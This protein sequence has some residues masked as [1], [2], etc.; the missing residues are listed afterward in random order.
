MLSFKILNRLV[1]FL[2]IFFCANLH[3]QVA[4]EWA[5][6]YGGAGS[7]G[8]WQTTVTSD[9]SGN[10]YLAGTTTSTSAISFN[11]HQNSFGGGTYDAFLVKFD[12]NGNRLW[13]TYYG[14]TGNEYGEA[15]ITDASGNI[16]LTGRTTSSSGI[17]SSG[18]LN[19]YAGSTDAFLVKFNS[20]GV[21]QWGTY[22]GG[23]NGDD[24][25]TICVDGSG[26]IYMSGSSAS[27]TGI[28][29]G[30]F[31]N[32]IGGG[33]GDAFLVKFD[34]NC[35][36]LWATYYGGTGSEAGLAITTDGLGNVY[37]TGQTTSTTAIA[38]GGFQNTHGGGT[39]DSYLV[40][41]TASG[42]RSWATYYGGTGQERSAG[43]TTDASNNVYLCGQTFSTNAIA[44]GGFQNGFGGGT[45]DAYLVKFNSTGARQWGTYYGG[46]G[47]DELVGNK[48]CA[49]DAAGN[50]Y[51]AGT[52]NSPTG[53]ASGGF[54]NANSG[55]SYDAFLVKFASNGSRLSATY[56]GDILYDSGRAI[57]LDPNGNI[58]LGGGTLSTSNISSGG[59]QSTYGGG[60]Y[61]AMLVK[62][63]ACS[64]GPSAPGTISGTGTI[65]SGSSNTYSVI[66]VPGATSYSW[67]LPSGW[68][69]TSTT[70]SISTTSDATSGNVIVIANNACGSSTAATLPITVNLP[71]STPG[72]ISGIS[73]IC[74]GSSNTYSVTAV[75]GATSYS[76]TLHSGWSGT[77]T[78]N[79][80]STTAGSTSGTI[81]VTANNTCGSSTAAALPITVN[82][83]PNTPGTISGTST[84]CSGLSNTYSVTADPGVTSY[85]WILPSG[86]S[87][88]STTNSISTTASSTSGTISVTANNTCGSSTA[89]TLPITVNTTPSTPG[90]ISG[91]STICSSSSNTYS[92]TAVSGATSYSWTLPS[93]W[94]GT[95]TTNS[96]STTAG[97]TSGT[98]SVTANNTCG[99]S[100]A[101]A[102][103]IT[104]YS[105][106]ATPGAISGASTIC[107]GS[108][109]SYSVTA[110]PGVSSY[111]WT[112]P[113]GWSGTSTN[114]S[115]SATASSTSGTITVTANNTCG[116]S[117]AATLPITVNSSPST[118]ST[119]SGTSTICSGSS[120]TYSVTAVPGATSYSWTLSSGWSGTSTTNSISTTASSTSGTITV[121]ANNTCG[122]S[123][124]ATLT[125]TVNSIPTTPGLISG[126][127]T[128]CS[129]SSNPYSITAVPGA[130]SYTWTLPSGWIGTSTTNSIST[131]AG[132]TSGTISV[133]A[134]NACGSSTA[135][136]LTI[137]VNSIPSTPGAISGTSTICS[138]SS[139]TYSVNTVPG[140]T[141]YS[142]TLP[143]GW[144]G[145][146]TAN[147]ISTTSD[148]TSGNITVT[149][150]NTC[151]SSTAA[152]LTITVNS[153]P[154]TP[155]A[156]SGTSSI[157]SGSSNTYSVTTVPGATSYTWT[158]PSGW[159]GTSTANSISTTASSTSGT[160]TVTANNTC[161][162]SAVA[163]LPIIV[164]SIP[165]T[166]GLIS[167]TSSI[168]SGS[169]NPYSV[170]AV[171][172]ATSY[173]WT[174]PSGWSGTS[175]TNSISTA[176]SSTSGTITV[177]ANNACGSS[178]A[179]TLPITV[180]SLP[181]VNLNLTV[182]TLCLNS[183]P[184]LM[185][186]GTPSGGIY[187]GTGVN[188]GIFDPTTNGTF[189]ITYTYT[190]GNICS[191]TITDNIVVE[192]CLGI[193]QKV[194]NND[195]VVYPNP[196]TNSIFITT[197]EVY[198]EL[199]I[200][201]TLGSTVFYKQLLQK[202]NEIDVS[203]LPSGVYYIN[204]LNNEKIATTKIV[205]Q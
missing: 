161:G 169:S 14:G 51:L 82:S 130:S 89:A 180:N 165:S 28:A 168:C 173:T 183:S 46:S 33:T 60:A 184:L 146:S 54:Q 108:L 186:G 126:T 118:P 142:W 185:S 66:A 88:T 193:N 34:A 172:G 141:S 52:T 202:Q 50:V 122:S 143:S 133:T 194:I 70:N 151:V 107:S 100:T 99:S 41:F 69:G 58:F 204:I 79:S 148:V 73:T 55:S 17:A 111:T 57:C 65:C 116:S 178:T 1:V 113:S 78:T 19:T 115:I 29:S 91:T 23:A 3:S 164:N 153:I 42:A 166:P 106:P 156:I 196:F 32:T 176:A 124:A 35:S 27:T 167:G 192:S 98:I 154:S 95:S 102:L 127:S 128:I 25:G 37:M 56:Y 31:Q 92:V 112:L 83:I 139:N 72:T 30:G 138:G 18:Y 71:P 147:S 162:S 105:I 189:T 75:S 7:E 20:A 120:N 96:I 24:A 191:N 4:R 205:K 77:S 197:N 175:T 200:F 188:S 22:Y 45:N 103:P 131:T 135:A 160:I 155:G 149:A 144:S 101:A 125:I 198:Q 179:Q 132:S 6:Y 38:S 174:L 203:E 9:A 121:T 15:I 94:G 61:D 170:T 163:T 12:A 86:W 201:N 110:D 53:I 104:V 48:L 181:T 40:K 190:D 85:T 8:E 26:N 182:D 158:L 171:S 47:F 76:W 150:N 157:C 49:T 123:T 5:T 10:V 21:R 59:F 159:S 137:T 145:T 195:I 119:I 36:R 177:T 44:S 39:W 87:G 136:T 67:T 13:A 2:S 117:T 81:S 97:S 11:G 129:A 152:T 43:V 140:A 114:N 134:N 109:N 63:A 68:S 93:G 90:V 199:F 187:S 84:I 74:S 62:F 80:I 16:Y 64:A